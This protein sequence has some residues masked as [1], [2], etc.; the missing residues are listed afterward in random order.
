[1]GLSIEFY[2]GDATR[3]G[4]AF[5]A[6]AFDE[7]RDGRKSI[8]YADLSLHLGMEDIDLLSAAVADRARQPL[9]SLLDGLRANVGRIDEEGSADVVDPAWVAMTST[10]EM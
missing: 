8:A 6:V 7:I 10:L 5:T 4:A 9:I 1:M 2:A 3:I